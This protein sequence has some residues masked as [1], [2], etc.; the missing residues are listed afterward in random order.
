[1]SAAAAKGIRVEVAVAAIVSEHDGIFTLN[2]QKNMTK[3]Q[4]L[5]NATAH[6]GTCRL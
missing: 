5:V 1:M 6:R 2:K 4:S 3:G